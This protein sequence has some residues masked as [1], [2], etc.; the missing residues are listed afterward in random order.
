[1]SEPS[2][3]NLAALIEARRKRAPLRLADLSKN[4]EKSPSQQAINKLLESN[5]TKAGFDLDKFGALLKQN[6]AEARQR[7]ATFRAESDKRSAAAED[8]LHQTVQN[9]RDGIK[10]LKALVPSGESGPVFL[11]TATEIVVDAGNSIR[12]LEFIPPIDV[13]FA[14][15]SAEENWA[16]YDYDRYVGP[17]FA[18]PFEGVGG[19][20]S[21]DASFGFLWQNP[22]D[23]YAVISVYC[24]IGINGTF[25]VLSDGGYLPGDRYSSLWIDAHLFIH[26]LWN[27][28]PTSPPEQPDQSRPV[29]SLHC[30]SYGFF[31]IGDI[32]GKD[33][34]EVHT[35]SYE[36]LIVPPQGK[37]MFEVA[38][39]AGHDCRYGRIQVVFRDPEA[40]PVG[41]QVMC[42]GMLIG[43]LN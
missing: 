30:H 37:V 34:N 1:M 20:G 11:T 6:D 43:I 31:S 36:Q 22:S 8:T 17:G 26:E 13:Y 5:L 27:D 7:M 25:V 40:M 41:R 39:S 14:Q 19:T 10:H 15:S 35:L 12:N 9:W 42:P 3:I 33:V 4:M 16:K 21:A 23:R 38:C 29:L 2:K 32:D 28:P 18:P 24:P